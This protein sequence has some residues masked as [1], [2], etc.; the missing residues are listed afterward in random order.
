MDDFD[1]EFQELLSNLKHS[2]QL[3]KAAAQRLGDLKDPRAIEP[4]IETLDKEDTDE[5]SRIVAKAL[6]AMGEVA[7]VPLIKTL[8]NKRKRMVATLALGIIRDKRAIQ[9]LIKV[10]NDERLLARHMASISL[11]NI[12]IEAVVPLI[13]VL[14]DESN[15]V[16]LW[17]VLTLQNIKDKRA[18]KPLINLLSDEDSNIRVWTVSALYA[19]GDAVAVEPLISALGDT[20]VEVRWWAIEALG[21]F[22]DI[23]ALPSLLQLQENDDAINIAVSGTIKVAATKAIDNI[24][25]RQK[26]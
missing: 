7:V 26:S 13:E 9:P 5:I 17:A 25:E 6:A 24:K 10:L 15:N 23:R 1:N 21:Q 2:G 8:D 16:R 14:N 22:G 4:L 3:R 12:G 18:V 19:L 11:V 20:D